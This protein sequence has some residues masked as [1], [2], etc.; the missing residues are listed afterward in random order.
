MLKKILKYFFNKKQIKR[1]NNK[2]NFYLKKEIIFDKIAL[3]V[4]NKNQ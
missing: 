1:L 3:K 2:K 4:L